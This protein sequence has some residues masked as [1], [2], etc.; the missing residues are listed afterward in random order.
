MGYTIPHP[1]YSCSSKDINHNCVYFLITV[2]LLGYEGCTA[3]S[4]H[5]ISFADTSVDT[6]V[7]LNA[8]I[9]DVHKQ[10]QAQNM[11]C[12]VP[13]ENVDIPNS[14]WHFKVV[15]SALKQRKKKFTFKKVPREQ[16]PNVILDP[17]S[18]KCYLVDGILNIS[19]MGR[20]GVK[21]KEETISQ[22]FDP[23]VSIEG[24]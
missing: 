7:C 15:Y 16:W 6:A 1:H 9:V 17:G 4:L 20:K 21:Q 24:N 3:K 8:C 12:S 22:L 19:F 10:L 18:T 11:H 23:D 13:I 2:G 14:C 5:L